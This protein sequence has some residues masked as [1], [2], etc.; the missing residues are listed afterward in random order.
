MRMG[1]LARVCQRGWVAVLLLL[2]S[3]VIAAELPPEIAADRLIVRAQWQAEEG[4]HGEALATLDEVVALAE[5]HG[6]PTPEAFWFRHAQAASAAGQHWVAVESSTRYLTAAGRNGEHYRAALQL[7]ETSERE[8]HAQAQREA[9]EARAAAEYSELSERFGGVDGV[10]ADVLRSGGLGP[11]MVVL[12]AGTFRMGCLS[13][14]DDCYDDEQPVHEVTIPSA[15]ALSAYEVS[16]AE[17]DACVSG[18]GCWGYRPNDEG[19]GRGARPVVKVSWKDAQDYVAWLSAE[20]GARYR[21]PSESEWE[22]AARAGTETKYSWGDEIGASRANCYGD[23]CRED[24]E[25]TAPVVSF[26]PNAWGLYDM[27]GNVSEWV[28]DCWNGSYAGAPSDGSAWLRG[29]CSRRVLRGGSWS[30]DPRNLRAAYRFR[31][32]AGGRYDDNGFRV[33][34]KLTP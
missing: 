13:N 34:R 8:L 16:F 23:R 7:L 30:D 33:A 20:T 25:R 32:S 28:E 24:W 2:A 1:P 31:S 15:F 9:W 29:E 26:G 14:D 5:E 4:R 11:E 12:P 6:L 27:H 17:W 10:F 18:G 21:L 3:V 19:W 22:Y